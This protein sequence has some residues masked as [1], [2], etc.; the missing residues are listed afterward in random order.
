MYLG[1]TRPWVFMVRHQ[2]EEVVPDFRPALSLFQ[3][4]P[5]DCRDQPDQVPVSCREKPCAQPH[6]VLLV[7]QRVH[8]LIT[9]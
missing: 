2:F 7:K 6:A 1:T 8:I 3:L 9:F 5:S 4:P